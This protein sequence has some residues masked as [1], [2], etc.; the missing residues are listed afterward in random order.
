MDRAVTDTKR[1]F[2]FRLLLCA[3][4]VAAV[5]YLSVDGHHTIKFNLLFPGHV[6]CANCFA[7]VDDHITWV[8]GWPIVTYV[9][10]SFNVAKLNANNRMPPEHYK[11]PS[12]RFSSLPVD[13]SPTL[14]FSWTGVLLNVA[15]L[16]F[17]VSLTWVATSRFDLPPLRFGMRTLLCGTTL[18]SL[19]LAFDLL[20]SR[21]IYVFASLTIILT[22]I[23]ASLW[24]L[25][26]NLFQLANASALQRDVE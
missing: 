8:H 1:P 4:V 20:T 19:L 2:G 14:A 21:Y 13:G 11:D 3:L 9:R 15:I 7:E 17:L 10:N 18:F 6:V 12:Y 26:Q 22:V 25:G 24:F 5:G 23:L 16:L